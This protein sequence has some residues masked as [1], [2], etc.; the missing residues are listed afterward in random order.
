ME[1]TTTSFE[2]SPETAR[3]RWMYDALL[4][5]HAHIRRD[6]DLI[7]AL[8][9]EAVDGADAEDLRRQ[10]RALKRDTMLWQLRVNCLRYCSFVHSHHGAE[11]ADFFTELRNTNPAI[12]PVIDRL[13]DEHRRVSGDLDAVEA[14]AKALGHDDSQKTRQSVVDTLRALERNLL[15]HLDYEERSIEATVR[16]VR[17]VS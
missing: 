11:D 9:E 7:K 2:V 13:R 5:V 1:L 14:A 6:L 16:R 8:A 3:G 12:N 4:A 17:E 15:A 10:L